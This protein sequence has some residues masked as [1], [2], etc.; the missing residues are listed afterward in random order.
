MKDQVID[1]VK[2][3]CGKVEWMNGVGHCFYDQ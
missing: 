2:W 3:L 1:E